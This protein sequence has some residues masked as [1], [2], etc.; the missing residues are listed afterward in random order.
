MEMEQFTLFWDGPFSQWEPSVFILDGVEYNCCE[1]YM[2]ACK[3]ALFEDEAI[4]EEIME[5]EDPGVQKALGRQVADF[6][7][8]VWSEDE[9]NG[10]PRCWNIVWRGNMAKFSQ[11]PYLLK[12]LL[13]TE[14]TT[15]AEA[16]PYDLI[17]GIGLRANDPRAKNRENWNGTNWLGEVVTS[18]RS[19]LTSDPSDYVTT[20]AD[21]REPV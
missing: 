7:A 4:L 11:N 1:Q 12:R 15:L 3:A 10:R 8:D 18:V 2:M 6:D 17:W 20:Y 16:S 9:D 5:A 14:G 13:E 21:Y 19:F